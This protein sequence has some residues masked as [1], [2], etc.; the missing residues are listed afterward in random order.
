MKVTSQIYIFVNLEIMR[1][2]P[3]FLL[4]DIRY[5]CNA[6]QIALTHGLSIFIKGN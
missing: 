3:V 2:K 6:V 5:F 1:P 4:I